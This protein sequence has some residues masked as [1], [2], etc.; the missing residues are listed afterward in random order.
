[1]DPRLLIEGE[2]ISGGDTAALIH[3]ILMGAAFG[4]YKL[5][6]AYPGGDSSDD[7]KPGTTGANSGGSN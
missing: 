3:L 1:M 7:D 5:V 6:K 2:S 4:L